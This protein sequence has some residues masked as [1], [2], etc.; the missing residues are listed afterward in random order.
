[1]VVSAFFVA[2]YIFFMIFF[3][4]KHRKII[5]TTFIVLH[6]LHHLA[7]WISY[8]VRLLFLRL[9]WSHSLFI[10]YL[11]E[12][13]FFS[14]CHGDSNSGGGGENQE[15]GFCIDFWRWTIPQ[16]V[17]TP[18]LNGITEIQTNQRSRLS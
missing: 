14:C 18:M 5:L 2:I 8:R 9:P 13:H 10:H 1:M 11:Q 7:R 16:H 15:V 17:R 6:V 4:S 12:G 3:S